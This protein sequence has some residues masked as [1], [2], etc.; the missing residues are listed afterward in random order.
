MDFNTVY[1]SLTSAAA[2]STCA[3]STTTRAALPAPRT[4]SRRG[5]SCGSRSRVRART[6]HGARDAL[7]LN[8]PADPDLV[9]HRGRR[10]IHRVVG[11]AADCAV[12]RAADCVETFA[13]TL[14]AGDYVLE[15]YEWTNTNA[16]RRRRSIRRSAAPAS[17]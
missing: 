5:A 7:P 9:L 16:T 10:S 13:P 4:S 15:V 6:R 11:G 1:D 2:R 14:Q 8:E 17:T 12:N 3:V